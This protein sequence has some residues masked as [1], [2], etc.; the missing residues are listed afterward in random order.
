MFRKACD[1]V[2][3]AHQRGVIHRDLKPG[4]IIVTETGSDSD[5]TTT[6]VSMPEVKIL[7]FGLAR[8]TDTDVQATMVSEVGTIKGTLGYMSP[9][10]ARGN[11]EEIDVRTDVYALGII[12]YEM[13]TG[14]RPYDVQRVSLIDAV[15]VICEQPPIPLRQQWSGVRR[16]DPDLETIVGKALE[17]ESEQR[18]GSA[19]ALSEDI[20][21]Y[22]TAQPILARPP[23]TT[24]QLR[25]LVQRHKLPFAFAATLVFLLIGFGI[26]MSF[27]YVRAVH[28]EEQATL[29]AETS[30]EALDFMVGMFE[31]SDPGEARGNSVTAREILD[32]GAERIREDLQHQPQV[33]SRLMETM[34]LVYRS[35]GLYPESKGLFEETR[36]VRRGYL[37]PDHIEVAE[38]NIRVA[39]VLIQSGKPD[40][41]EPLLEQ[42]LAVQERELDPND[43]A[44][45]RTLNNLGI[46]AVRRR[47][48]ERARDLWERALVI[49]ETSLGAEDPAV[50]KLL[51]VLSVSYNRLGEKDKARDSLMRAISILEA[52]LGHDHP[53]VAKM[54]H[55]LAVQQ[56]D[57]GE[58]DDALS[59]ATE[60]LAIKEKI[61]E[62]E[63]TSIAFT[64]NT[65]GQIHVGKKSPDDARRAFQRAVAI[66]DVSRGEADPRTL[67]VRARLIGVFLGLEAHDELA[68]AIETQLG[69]LDA[70]SEARDARTVEAREAM[71][72]VLEKLGRGQ[73]ARRLRPRASNN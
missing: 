35:L 69:A 38:A 8:I 39:S 73:E 32:R 37:G 49:R 52:S 5:V 59:S 46:V 10:Q 20:E 3:Y 68:S 57:L 12:I 42:A 40:E 60:S 70:R 14:L 55:N 41:A 65:L 16:L 30:T 53:D 56:E 54:L 31:V 50:A 15:R 66:Y 67:Q 61:Y 71:V 26:G 25:K 64:L 72:E 44:I 9:E 13:L 45:A 62:P 51:G 22:L 43:P 19:A 2:Q 48:Y 63:H 33:Q 24:Y 21:R 17:K 58:L 4:N 23:S 27:L 18:Y 1:A 47:D 11:P 28:A 7:D 34:G 29:E 6:D 36:E